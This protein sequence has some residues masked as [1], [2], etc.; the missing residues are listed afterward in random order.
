M[1]EKEVCPVPGHSFG[2]FLLPYPSAPRFAP[3]RWLVISLG[4]QETSSSGGVDINHGRQ[5][6]VTSI[7]FK[8]RVLTLSETSQ[9]MW[10][11]HFAGIG[12][13]A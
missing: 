7:V 3:V 1:D 8:H 13:E 6:M 11:K 5:Q 4:N 2:F 9:I 10:E 12:Q